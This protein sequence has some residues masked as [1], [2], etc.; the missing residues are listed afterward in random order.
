MVSSINELFAFNRICRKRFNAREVQDGVTRFQ[1]VS[2]IKGSRVMKVLFSL[3][4]KQCLLLTLGI[5]AGMA[6]WGIIASLNQSKAQPHEPVRIQAWEKIAPRLQ[7]A[8]KDAAKSGKRHLDRISAYFAEKRLHSRDFAEDALGWGGKWAFIQGKL[9]GDE[10]KA[11]QA[12]LRIAFERHFFTSRDLQNLLQ[13]VI[14]AYLTELEG[15]ENELLVAIRA[16][17]SEQDFPA[18]HG[19]T[20]LRSDEVFK[21]EYRKMLEQVVPAVGRDLKITVGREAVVWVGS[22]IAGAV[23]VR[24]ASAVAVRLGVS[25]GILGTGAASGVATLG[26][27][28]IVG[29]IVDGAADWAMRRAGYD[30]AGK[31]A[32][33]VSSTIGHIEKLL[34]RGDEGAHSTYE[35]L[36]SMQDDDPVPFVRNACREAADRIETGGSLGLG[37]ELYRLQQLR[38]RLRQEALKKLIL[39]GGAS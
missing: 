39:E 27:G 4:R 16:D 37:R 28:L 7:Q 24:I 2:N 5:L 19:V 1:D 29:F 23:T 14:T 35:Q 32:S 18:L 15:H 22:E 11:H 10:G 17:L 13:S 3:G 25:G 8:D 12:H 36:R 21:A 30:P 38:S 20:A 31:I 26:V 34:V 9:T 6:A 33:E